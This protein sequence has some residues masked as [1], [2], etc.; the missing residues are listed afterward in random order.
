MIS[1]LPLLFKW[2]SELLKASTL[3][4]SKETGWSH[5]SILSWTDVDF[6]DL[7]CLF[8]KGEIHEYGIFL[9]QEDEGGGQFYWALGDLKFSSNLGGLSQMGRLKSYT[10]LGGQQGFPYW[11]IGGVPHPLTKNLLISL[12]PEKVLPPQINSFIPP[13]KGSFPPLNN[14]KNKPNKKK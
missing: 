3:K 11:G 1:R 4:S 10:L 14:K 5:I 6:F 12:P 7:E 9:P 13:T 2:N 8:V